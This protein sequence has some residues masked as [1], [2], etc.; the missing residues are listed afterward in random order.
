MKAEPKH[1]AAQLLQAEVQDK[2]HAYLTTHLQHIVDS[3][4]YLNITAEEIKYQQDVEK[5]KRSG[6]N[7]IE[8][9]QGHDY[10]VVA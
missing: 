7:A 2:N 9:L 5:E 3:T 8:P 1:S 4:I 10:Q 6:Q